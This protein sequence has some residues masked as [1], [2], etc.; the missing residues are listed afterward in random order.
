MHYWCANMKSGK[1]KKMIIELERSAQKY[2]QLQQII[3]KEI[4]EPYLEWPFTKQ[5]AESF[6]ANYNTYGIWIQWRCT[7]WCSGSQR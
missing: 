5:V 7:C 2:I 4:A 1:K 3:K 6:I